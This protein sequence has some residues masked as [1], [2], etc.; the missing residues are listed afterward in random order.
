[1]EAT[2]IILILAV[3]YLIPAAGALVSIQKLIEAEKDFQRL[4]HSRVLPMRQYIGLFILPGLPIV[5]IIV[6]IY[7]LFIYLASVKKD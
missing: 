5:N 7:A 4:T 3:F 2:A 6:S 1:M